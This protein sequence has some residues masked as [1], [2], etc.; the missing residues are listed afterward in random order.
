MGTWVAARSGADQGKEFFSPSFAG[1]WPGALD[2]DYEGVMHA[3]LPPPCPRCGGRLWR[4]LSDNESY[5]DYQHERA[6]RSWRALG[7][8]GP[9][10]EKPRVERWLAYRHDHFRDCVDLSKGPS[11]IEPIRPHLRVGE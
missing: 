11:R 5:I 1:D 3:P 10:P 6:L 7:S 2:V 4:W 8:K 9:E